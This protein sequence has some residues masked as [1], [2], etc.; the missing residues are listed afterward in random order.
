[1]TI[2]LNVLKICKRRRG[3][4]DSSWLESGSLDTG[5]LQKGQSQDEDYVPFLNGKYAC[6]SSAAR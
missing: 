1:M 4:V 5:S 3:A 6:G 2:F